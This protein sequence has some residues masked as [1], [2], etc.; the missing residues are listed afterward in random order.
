MAMG[1]DT[2][3][4]HPT[5]ATLQ[6]MASGSRLATDIRMGVMDTINRTG[7]FHPTDTIARITTLTARIMDITDI[8][9]VTTIGHIMDTVIPSATIDQYRSH[10]FQGT[11]DTEIRGRDTGVSNGGNQEK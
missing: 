2:A 1:T 8:I 5:A 3:I 11:V 10:T 4:I 6:L 9:R 7:I